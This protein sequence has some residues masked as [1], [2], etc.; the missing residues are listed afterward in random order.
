MI[1]TGGTIAMRDDSGTGN[2]PM[3]DPERLLRAAPRLRELADVEPIDWGLVPASHLT[4]DQV[5]DIGR[6][7]RD[8]LERPDIDAAVVVQGTDVIEET[9]FAWDLL[10]LPAKP[11]V[12][13]GAMR[14]ASQAE[15]D[16]PANLEAAVRAAGEPALAERGVVVVMAGE[17]HAAGDVRKTDTHALSTFA[18]P[19]LAR[20]GTVGDSRVELERGWSPVRL[21]AIPEQAA[22]PISVVTFALDM[23]TPEVPARAGAPP[24]GVVLAAAGSGNAPPALLAFARDMLDADVPV[25]LTTRCPAGR[26]LPGYAFDGGSTQ[27][28][29]AGVPFSGTLGALKTRVLLALA[30][31]VGLALDEISALLAPY[32]GG[33]AGVN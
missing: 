11:V 8:A 17:I 14:S 16:G 19:N 10:P 15:Y 7:L 4:F 1:F 18:S 5:L 32:G 20:L 21:P 26:P 27:W 29:E 33:R 22:L 2:R 6:T 31:G 9:A 23:E 12:V 28:W 30:V 13:T 24:A 25:V 3:L